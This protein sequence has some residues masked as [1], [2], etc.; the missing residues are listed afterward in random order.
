MKRVPEPDL[1]TNPEQVEAYG[2][3]DFE[4]THSNFMTFIRIVKAPLVIGT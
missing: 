2:K 1:M 3:A 4:E